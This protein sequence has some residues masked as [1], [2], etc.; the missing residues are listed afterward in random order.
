MICDW[1]STHLIWCVPL[2]SF[3]MSYVVWAITVEI[4]LI[5]LY[6]RHSLSR[7]LY[8]PSL[9][10]LLEK[11]KMCDIACWTFLRVLN[12]K[13]HCLLAFSINVR[14]L[15][16]FFLILYMW[17][18]LSLHSL[19]FLHIWFGSLLI[20]LDVFKEFSIWRHIIQ[21]WEM[22]FYYFFDNFHTDYFIRFF[23]LKLLLDFGPYGFFLMLDYIS[24]LGG[25][26]VWD[27]YAKI[28]WS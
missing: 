26:R 28:T 15:C 16:H 6:V 1:C 22:F 10:G 25:N 3:A 12:A 27:M 24:F 9:W 8:H 14:T 18:S 2:F 4:F 23:L 13:F 5:S 17:S 11:G 19:E 21:F 7:V 20:L